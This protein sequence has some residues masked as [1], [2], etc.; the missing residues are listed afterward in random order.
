MHQKL[1]EIDGDVSLAIGKRS[2]IPFAGKY[3]ADWL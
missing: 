1:P 3:L 2:A